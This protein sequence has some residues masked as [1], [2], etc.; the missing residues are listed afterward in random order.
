MFETR[1][2]HLDEWCMKGQWSPGIF[3]SSTTT[4]KGSIICY[5]LPLHRKMRRYALSSLWCLSSKGNYSSQWLKRL[6]VDHG[7]SINI[8][9]RSVFDKML[10]DHELTLMTFLLDG[11][12]RDSIIT[13][14][15]ITFAIKMGSPLQV[16]RNFMELLVVANRSTYHGVLGRSA[17][18]VMD[19]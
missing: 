12:L 6:L 7:S 11:F 4:L 19:G 14:R 10:V 9:L 15:K 13:R 18:R 17:W 5:L 1:L 8:M 2:K 3:T 16:V